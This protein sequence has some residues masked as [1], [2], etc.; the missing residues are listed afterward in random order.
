MEQAQLNDALD[1]CLLYH[2]A[3]PYF[4]SIRL[5]RVCGLS[6]YLPSMGTDYLNSFYRNQIS[7]NEATQL[8]K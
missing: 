4:L 6:M 1:A 2:A 8:V 3:T 5:S 7:W